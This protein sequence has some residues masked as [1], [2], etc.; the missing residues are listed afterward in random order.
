MPVT[1]NLYTKLLEVQ[2]SVNYL[3]KENSGQQFSYVSSSQVLA[4]IKKSMDEQGLL[5][6]PAITAHEVL[7]S[8]TKSGTAMYFTEL[9]IEFTWINANKPDETLKIPFYSQGTDLAGEKGV[10]KALTYAEK[11]FLL[12]F[13][14]IATD[15]DDPDAFQE[16][17][18]PA[19]E[20]I[21]DEEKQTLIK[22]VADIA[23]KASEMI[24][25]DKSDIYK[26]II[27]NA[28]INPNAATKEDAK[29][30]LKFAENYLKKVEAKHEKEEE[31]KK[32]VLK[33]PF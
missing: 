27:K 13:F 10:G 29:A 33:E 20:Y 8:S 18:K 9:E 17:N 24:G 32:D 2:K 5:L 25:Q 31:I 1:S 21:K 22:A 15:K 28:K 14:H 6:A 19:P 3:Q 11:Y 12:K 7:Q 4:S 26:A 23:T 16:R 30:L